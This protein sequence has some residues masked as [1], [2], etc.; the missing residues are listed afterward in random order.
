LKLITGGMRIGVSSRLMKQALADY[1]GKDVTEIEEL[2]HGLSPP[3]LPLFAWLD[4]KAA[5]PENLAAAPF[6]PV[7]LAN[8]TDLD[9]LPLR[10]GRLSGRVEMGRHPRAGDGR[11]GVS[12]ASIRAPATTSP[13]P[14]RTC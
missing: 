5:K 2:W 6:R 10:S 13:A 4:G 3:Y 8:P 14:S 9:E 7:M 11:E 1:G 12:T